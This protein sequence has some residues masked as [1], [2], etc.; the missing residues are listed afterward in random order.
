MGTIEAVCFDLDGTLCVRDQSDE[1]VYEAV[2][3][4]V[5]APAFFDL[6]D[7]YAVD[8]SSLPEAN[9]DREHH[10]HIYRAIARN[11]GADPSYAPRLAE[12]TLEVLD[13]TAVSFRD[14]ANEVLEYVRETY[15]VGL[16]TAGSEETQ[17]PKLETLGI[18]DAFD[19]TVCC[20]PGTGIESKPNPEPFEIALDELGS[21]PARSIYVGNQHDRDVVGPQRVGMQTAWVPEEDVSSNPKPE[22]T[23]H[24]SWMHEITDIL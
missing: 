12:A 21:S 16:I 3:D 24:L 14:G 9:S 18:Q 19:V 5:E 17:L 8:Y 10:E 4:R 1:E 22:P 15:A 13:P 6:A 11:V 2:F 23:F 7:I 20:G